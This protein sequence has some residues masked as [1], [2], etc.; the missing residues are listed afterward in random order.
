[1]PTKDLTK[2]Q[3]AVNRA[4]EAVKAK[5]IPGLRRAVFTPL[6]WLGTDYRFATALDTLSWM[7]GPLESWTT[8]EVHQQGRLIT[9][10]KTLCKFQR[11]S[12]A[13]TV[14]V[15]G[16]EVTGISVAHA[17]D[18]GFSKPWTAPSYV[19]EQSFTEE[20]VRIQPYW[21]WPGTDA[22]INLPQTTGKHPAVLFLQGSGPN[23]RDATI[24]ATKPFKDLACG[25]AT[26]GFVTM[27]VDKPFAPLVFKQLVT[28]TLT[29]H[30]EYITPL[31]A[32]LRYL[33]I[34]P[35]V[36]PSRIFLLG[37]SQGGCIAP[38]LAR[39]SP[40]PI[41]G[42]VS[43]AGVTVPLMRAF[44]KQGRY[45]HDHFPRAS[46]EEAEKEFQRYVDV[47]AV[48]DAGGLKPGQKDPTKDLPVPLGLEYLLDGKRNH[49]VEIARGLDMPMLIIQ[50]E[51]DWQVDME[52][53]EGWKKGLEGS[54][55]MKNVQWKVY[56]DVGHMLTVVDANKRGAFQY[57]EF[58]NVKEELVEDVIAFLRQGSS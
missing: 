29:M 40:V 5:D 51:R 9:V 35:A 30:D 37:H 10:Y 44:E 42:F 41:T 7:C 18:I 57:A 45:L 32:A 25:L 36:D 26:A 43:L 4:L 17:I 54:E 20:K 14:S 11:S 47:Q 52:S 56:D 46:Q 58:A 33:N 12:Q 34:H 48:V 13:I 2:G 22:T 28:K 21:I 53:Y 39:D 8:P 16:N 55:A 6:S 27:R 38:R 50:G 15:W 31:I 24:Y 1:M 23:D 49:P 19:D 3:N